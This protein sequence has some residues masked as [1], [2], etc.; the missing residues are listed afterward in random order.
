MSDELWRYRKKEARAPMKIT[1]NKELEQF[2]GLSRAE[3]DAVNE[4]FT[5]YVFYRKKGVGR[6]F[7]TSCCHAK[8]RY[9]GKDR[10]RTMTQED[11]D[12]LW[13]GHND[14]IYCPFCGRWAKLKCVGKIG[15]GAALEEYQPVVFLRA[16]KDGQTIWA[17]GYWS[18]KEYAK[19]NTDT[20]CAEPLYMPSVA[21]RFRPGEAVYWEKMYYGE[22]GK[23]TES[24][25]KEPFKWDSVY[26]GIPYYSVIGLER[27]KESF[28]R[29][30]DVPGALRM[31]EP[32][33]RSEKTEV[34]MRFL[35]LAAQY[36]QQVEML[37]KM[38]LSDIVRDWVSYKKKNAAVLRW[39][40]TDPRKAFRLN[41]AELKEWIESGGN[42]N[43]LLMRKILLK[44][45]IPAG[46]SEAEQISMELNR[47]EK[48][49]REIFKRAE[50]WHAEGK[51][52]L[53][54][55]QRLTG[56][57][58][59]GGGYRT[60]G[61]VLQIWKDYL[62]AAEENGVELWKKKNLLPEDLWTAHDAK[63]K[64]QRERREAQ[65]KKAAMEKAERDRAVWAKRTEEVREKYALEM[66]GLV[67]VAPTCEQD[68]LD[69]GKALCHCVGGYADRHRDGRTTILFLR[70]AEAPQEAFL[71]IEM[72]GNRLVQIHGYRNEGLYSGKGRF[73]PDPKEVYKDWLE[74]WL[75]WLK[76]GSRR[77]KNGTPILPKPKK[78]KQAVSA[79]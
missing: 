22:W 41:S 32:Y 44:N 67:I 64:K 14:S 6:E 15:R 26:S 25:G 50:Q 62:N 55:L 33:N 76:A 20:L 38:G 54:Y 7:W 42:T 47:D 73:A 75:K 48:S 58:H 40:E 2:P 36:P 39:N 43:A 65:Q 10:T 21:Y 19:E 56:G 79:A 72:N 27:L 45:G 57:C 4:L 13:S 60:M 53:R 29:Y 28:L 52:V 1:A 11:R 74:V 24:F 9:L 51:T 8:G 69:E 12:A 23:K 34:L 46:I 30:I 31:L 78:K 18:R 49:L 3:L 16:S 66:D 5:P 63:T 37:L 59:M 35:Q 70:R 71:T 77:R 68:I 61:M 17:Q